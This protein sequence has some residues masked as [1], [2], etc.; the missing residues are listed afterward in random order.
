MEIKFKLGDKV[1]E[2]V[3]MRVGRV[4]F[5]DKSSWPVVYHVKLPSGDVMECVESRLEYGGTLLGEPL[6]DQ[7]ESLEEELEFLVF[8]VMMGKYLSVIHGYLSQQEEAMDT[9]KVIEI[10][11][12]NARAIMRSKYG[13]TEERVQEIV[14]RRIER[15]RE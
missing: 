6:F 10:A 9:A 13:L 14:L 12:A 5:I 3:S 4:L 2:A 1:V 15:N 7:P 8:D 11:S